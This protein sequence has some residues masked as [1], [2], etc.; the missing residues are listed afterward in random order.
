MVETLSF[1]IISISTSLLLGE[2]GYKNFLTFCH[3]GYLI[4]MAVKS[5][6][7][8]VTP[9]LPFPSELARFTTRFDIYG[10]I[11]VKNAVH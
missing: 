9:H 5:L 8:S 4:S 7:L 1:I 10:I 2:N 11:S 6:Y 3:L